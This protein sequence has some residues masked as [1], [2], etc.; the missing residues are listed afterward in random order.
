MT[1]NL[2]SRIAAQPYNLFL[3]T[4]FLLFIF[5]FVTWGQST[6]LHLHD[7]YFVVSTIYFI[8]FLAFILLLIWTVYKLIS[9]I[10]WTKSLTWF[11]VIGTLLILLLLLTSALWY[12]PVTTTSG[13]YS[14][15]EA[16]HKQRQK[17]L[18]AFF[19]IAITLLLGQLAFIVNLL[20]GLIKKLISRT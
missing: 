1:K 20:G 6:D 17:E 9:R 4:A 11:H 19:L 8:W 18:I 3:L 16:F 10:L 5:S 7:T 15:Y 14:P 12:K 13:E 2:K